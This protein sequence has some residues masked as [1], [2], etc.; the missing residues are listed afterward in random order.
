MGARLRRAFSM[1]RL[2]GVAMIVGF[3]AIYYNDPYPVQFVRAKTFDFYQKLKPREIP[4][5]KVSR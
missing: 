3:I 5:P 2:I 4:P 1:E